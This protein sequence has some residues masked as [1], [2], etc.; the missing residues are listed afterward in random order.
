MRTALKWTLIGVVVVFGAIQLVPYGRDHE[1]PP[2]EVEPAWAS[3]RTEDLAGVACADCHSNET[4]WPW[5][6]HVAPFSWLAQRD[7][8]NGREAWNW[9]EG[10]GDADDA[11][12]V[13]ADGEMPPRQY[14]L[15]HPDARL[16]SRERADLA[17]GLEATFSERTEE[18][19][20]DG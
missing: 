3:A 8:E 13:T 17:A 4:E 2:V 10:T 14:T 12:E 6:S 15:A 7:V 16:S 11:G 1:N 20:D 5:Y 9:S 18:D 19:D